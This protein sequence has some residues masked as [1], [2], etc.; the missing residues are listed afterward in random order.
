MKTMRMATFLL[1]CG[2]VY[3]QDAVLTKAFTVKFRRVDEVA[4]MINRML[5]DKGAVTLRPRLRTVVVQ[6]YEKNLRKIE[7][8]VSAFDMPSPSVE[9]SV[10]LVQA[11]KESGASIVS[12]EIKSMAKIGQVLR[13]NH[14]SLLDSGFI[15]SEEGK[16]S[17]ILLAK[18][19]QL[20]FLPAV[21][22]EG[23]GIIRLKDF[24]LNKRKKDV[25]G[26]EI[27]YPLISVTLNLRDSETLILGASRFEDSDHALLVVL[28]AK[29]KN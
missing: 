19:Y 3:A 8:A 4:S 13:F 17:E 11:K 28:L 14:F 21:I 23:N 15:E 29:V 7:L 1:A 16:T 22:Q 9:I 2:L 5:S 6:D 27:F 24:Q 25:T 20:R 12:E 18:D 26:K 10:K